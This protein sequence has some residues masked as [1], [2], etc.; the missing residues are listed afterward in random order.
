MQME[1]LLGMSLVAAAQMPEFRQTDLSQVER[2]EDQSILEA[3][4]LG[5]SLILPDHKHIGAVHL[6]SQGHE[7]YSKFVGELPGGIQFSDTRAVVRQRLG[8]PARSGETKSVPLLGK[9]PPYDIYP[10]G[11]VTMRVQYDFG[12]ER[13]LL[14]TLSRAVE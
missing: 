9:I 2:I 7:G 5:F 11:D 8:S 13:V 6:Y 14:V 3:P 10:L 1:T 12:G 4:A